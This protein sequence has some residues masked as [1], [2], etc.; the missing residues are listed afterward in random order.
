MGTCK[1]W[2]VLVLIL[3]NWNSSTGSTVL[4]NKREKLVRAAENYLHVREK[5]GHNDGK[6]VAKILR[7]VGLS[8]GNAWCAAL[9]AQCFD[10]AGIPNPHSAYCPDWFKTDIVYKKTVKVIK[11]FTSQLGQTVGF[12]IESKR[13]VGHIGMITGETKLS[14]TTI[15]GNTNNAG[16]DE[17]DGCYRKIRNKRTIYIISDHV[18]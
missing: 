18:K 3:W 4:D 15:E 13:R 7:N 6:Y 5:T 10:D 2:I 11:P 1:N 12:Y 14:Y 17:G 16:S 9:M 8:E